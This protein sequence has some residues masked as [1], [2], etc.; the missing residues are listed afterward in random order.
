[1]FSKTLTVI[2]SVILVFAT[3]S[4][5]VGQESAVALDRKIKAQVNDLGAGAKVTVFMKDGTKVRGSISQILDDSFDVTIK[6]QTQSSILSYRDVQTVKRRG[7]TNSAKLGLGVAIGAAAVV[8]AIV[9]L[10]SSKGL[11]GAFPNSQP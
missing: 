9:I 8:A 10:V 3:P 4:L 5:I 1:M 6:D 7:W 11:D 2:L